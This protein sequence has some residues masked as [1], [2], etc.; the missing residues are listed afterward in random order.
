MIIVTYKGITKKQSITVG[1]TPAA[2]ML[3]VGDDK[4]RVASSNVYTLENANVD[5][6]TFSIEDPKSL[7]KIQPHGNS[8]TVIANDKNKLGN[9]TLI[10]KCGDKEFSKEISVVSLW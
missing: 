10:A 1:K 9:F 7:V 8:C 4:I 2:K 3:F 5:N 6:V